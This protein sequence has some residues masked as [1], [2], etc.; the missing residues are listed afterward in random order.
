MKKFFVL[1]ALLSTSF[2]VFANPTNKPNSEYVLDVYQYCIQEFE[3]ET[4]NDSKLL[5][6]VNDEMKLDDYPTYKS[7]AAVKAELPKTKQKPV[8][9]V[10][11]DK[12]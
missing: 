11:T 7:I 10:I 1:S 4:L 3:P 9:S 12:P 8:N 6:C 2:A 5:N